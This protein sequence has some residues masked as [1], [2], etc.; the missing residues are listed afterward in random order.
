MPFFLLLLIK[1][2]PG[3]LLQYKAEHELTVGYQN[4]LSFLQN[5]QGRIEETQGNNQKDCTK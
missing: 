5:I 3:T 1:L 4:A 2:A